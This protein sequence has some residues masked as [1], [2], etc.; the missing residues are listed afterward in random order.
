MSYHD[1]NELVQAYFVVI[2]FYLSIL[3]FL[4]AEWMIAVLTA[5]RTIKPARTVFVASLTYKFL[6]LFLK[7]TGKNIKTL[8]RAVGTFAIC[9]AVKIF[10]TTAC[11]AFIVNVLIA[12]Q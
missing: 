10:K 2:V 5:K 12:K 7:L 1:K 6:K 11:H 9:K 3:A 4:D 8:A